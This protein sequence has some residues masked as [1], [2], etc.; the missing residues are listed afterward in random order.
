ME[1]RK[2]IH[3]KLK[4]K[5]QEIQSLE[6][7][8]RAAR[9]YVQAL[10]DILKLVGADSPAEPAESAI[11]AG[12]AVDKAREAILRK[13]KPLHIND[14]IE[15]MGKEVTR[16]SR[17][18]L[19]SSIAAY[20][21]RGEIFTRPAPNTFGLV[22]LGHKT[23]GVVA[24]QPQPPQGFGRLAQPPGPRVSPDID[25]EIPFGDADVKF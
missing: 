12:S 7:K 9:I 8:L 22:E 14:L 5:E 6:E 19:T 4:K 25:D 24:H 16:K 1:E 17:A 13:N 11:K 20:V 18:S 23:P 21:R 15:A 2:A 10:Q 3:E